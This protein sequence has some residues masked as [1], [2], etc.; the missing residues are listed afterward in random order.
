[1]QVIAG[2]II[3]IEY[4]NDFL[5]DGKEIFRVEFQKE[6]GCFRT[7]KPK[8]SPSLTDEDFLKYHDIAKNLIDAY[9]QGFCLSRVMYHWYDTKNERLT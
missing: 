6:Q 3:L 7:M 4:Q 5:R 1:M 8:A 9:F 2:E